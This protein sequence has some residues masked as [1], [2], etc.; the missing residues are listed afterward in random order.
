MEMYAELHV[1]LINVINII[2][3]SIILYK[4]FIEY[5]ELYALNC[6]FKLIL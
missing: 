4:L 1:P 2:N 5:L 6:I 3:F